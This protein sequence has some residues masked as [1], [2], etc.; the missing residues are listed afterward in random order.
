MSEISMD[1]DV[2][3]DGS[4]SSLVGNM[5]FGFLKGKP[6]DS[7][8]PKACL[9]GLRVLDN[10]FSIKYTRNRCDWPP[11]IEPVTYWQPAA[12][13]KMKLKHIPLV[14]NQFSPS[15]SHRQPPR[16][17]AGSSPEPQLREP[18]N[19]MV[20]VDEYKWFLSQ[21]ASPHY[22]KW[23]LLEETE[24]KPWKQGQDQE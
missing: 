1:R 9:T 6:K 22:Q 12:L 17:V 7:K 21:P 5:V 19:R 18:E 3:P 10:R 2:E 23:K 20:R 14:E 16:L 24:G 8:T 11:S 4:N 15:P 13:E